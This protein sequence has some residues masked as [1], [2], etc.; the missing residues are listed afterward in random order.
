MIKALFTRYQ[1]KAI[2]VTPEDGV[3]KTRAIEDSGLYHCV[4]ST[5]AYRVYIAG[6]AKKK[7]HR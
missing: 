4:A 7:A 2:V 6:R 5:D 1:V 3:W